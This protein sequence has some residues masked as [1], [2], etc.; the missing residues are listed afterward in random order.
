MIGDAAATQRILPSC[1]LCTVL[2]HSKGVMEGE[3]KERVVR[4]RKNSLKKMMRRKGV[5]KRKNSF[6]KKRMRIE[7]LHEKE[8][9]EVGGREEI[10]RRRWEEHEGKE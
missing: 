1:E 8:D 9:E 5:R 4:K 3:E 2:C 7:E 10:S 6:K